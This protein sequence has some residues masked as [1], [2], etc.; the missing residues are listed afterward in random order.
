MPL[1]PGQCG[2]ADVQECLPQAASLGPLGTLVLSHIDWVPTVLATRLC[3]V[4]G[5][6]GK[7]RTA[8]T[9]LRLSGARLSSSEAFPQESQ[10]I[11]YPTSHRTQALLSEPFPICNTL[12]FPKPLP[13]TVGTLAMGPG[14][15]PH[16][17]LSPGPVS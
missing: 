15:F 13:W 4:K 14:P 16:R 7:K 11:H 9:P 17:S 2:V 1:P 12:T 3:A 10:F 8:G 5:I 6:Q